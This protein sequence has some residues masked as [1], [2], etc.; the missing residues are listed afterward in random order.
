ME[1]LVS[2]I[3]NGNAYATDADLAAHFRV[4]KVTIWRWA[5]GGFPAPVKLSPQTTRWRWSEVLAWEDEQSG[6]RAKS[7]E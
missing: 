4:S 6:H 3:R 1:N 5:K 7:A 2:Q